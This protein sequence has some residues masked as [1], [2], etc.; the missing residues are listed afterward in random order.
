MYNDNTPLPF[1]KYKFTALGRVPAAYLVELH[2]TRNYRGNE[3]LKD[4]IESNLG[5]LADRAE[6]EGI[7]AKVKKVR[8]VC[9]KQ[10][11]ESEKA[12]KAELRRIRSLEQ[13]HKKPIRSYPCDFCGG[14]HL[15]S[16]PLEDFLQIKAQ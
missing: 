3:Q 8:S 4:Y 9:R 15:T 7:N 5:S 13:K 14:F 12:A 2:R 1:G 10:T 11:F 16:V 6:R